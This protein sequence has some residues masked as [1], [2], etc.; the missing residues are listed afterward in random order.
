[1]GDSFGSRLRAARERAK[2]TQPQLAALV[3]VS[4]R[5]IGNWERDEADP[6]NSLTRL[7]DVLPELVGPRQQDEPFLTFPDPE[8]PDARPVTT[9][10]LREELDRVRQDVAAIVRDEIRKALPG[11]DT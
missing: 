10:E 5:T 2:L 3:G 9:R 8:D 11:A 1:M 6:R 7:Q 4:G